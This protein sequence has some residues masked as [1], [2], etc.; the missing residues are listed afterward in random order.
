MLKKR[1]QNLG[2]RY[3]QGRKYEYQA[4]KKLKEMGFQLI[5]RSS[6]SN[7]IFD[8][9]GL[10]GNKKTRRVSEIRCI[11]VKATNSPFSIK[12]IFPKKER[13]NIINNKCLPVLAKNIFYEI[14]IWRIR[15]GWD[16]YRL[17]WKRKEFEKLFLK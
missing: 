5:I 3:V 10:K 2:R 17:N 11:Q 9:F 16:I 4:I 12:S 6:R 13:G 7:G 14:W 8:I 1:R 15:E